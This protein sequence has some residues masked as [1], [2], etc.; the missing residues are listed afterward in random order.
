VK[1]NAPIAKIVEAKEWQPVRTA[2]LL[3]FSVSQVVRKATISGILSARR[4]KIPFL[5]SLFSGF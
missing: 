4:E 3:F 2:F 1:K 5:N